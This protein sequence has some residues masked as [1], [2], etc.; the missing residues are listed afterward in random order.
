MWPTIAILFAG[1]AVAAFVAWWLDRRR[2]GDELSR[3]K[4]QESGTRAKHELN[5]S[6]AASEQQA[7]FNSMIEGVLVL[8]ESGAVRLVNEAFGGLFDLRQ[9]LK[10]RSLMEAVRLHEIQEIY[11]RTL[12]E[13]V[14][15]GFELD[16][17]AP[18]NRTL[19]INSTAVLDGQGNR[20]GI[21][22][23]FHDIT[24]I[25]ELENTRREF[26]ANVSHELRTPLSMIK[27]YVETLIDGAKN[28][29]EVADKFLRTIEKHADRLTFLIEDLLTLSRMETGNL[30][31]NLQRTNLAEAVGRVCDDLSKR[32]AER[33]IDLI[34]A[35]DSERTVRADS[36]RLEQVLFNL[37]DNGIKYGRASGNVR[38]LAA[39]GDPEMVNICVA[40][41]G[42]GIPDEAKCRLFE[43]FFRVDTARSREQG[44]TGLG[45]AITKHIVQSH[46]GDLWVESEL[47]QGTSFFFSLKK[48]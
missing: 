32:A 16:L 27:G 31:M 9:D 19:Q 45:L 44:G 28:E 18:V 39:D 4:Q 5:R 14:V 35:I 20:Q 8:D 10:G 25:K 15:H 2:M 42:P 23:V 33:G 13:V 41:D 11:D 17:A 29:P 12:V 38:I 37:I 30:V 6:A 1:L 47:G 40:D 7:L 24:R 3:L 34:N 48:D 43:R 46:G 21:I 22:I 36:D 26:V